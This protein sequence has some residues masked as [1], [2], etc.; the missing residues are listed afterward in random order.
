MHLGTG[1]VVLRPLVLLRGDVVGHRVLNHPPIL[2]LLVV[3]ESELNEEGQGRFWPT[4]RVKTASASRSCASS[5]RVAAT[6]TPVSFCV[7]RI[8]RS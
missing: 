8:S 6:R 5:S 1:D 7:V 2:G 4:S 3:R